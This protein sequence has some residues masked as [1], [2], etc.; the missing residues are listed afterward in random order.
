MTNGSKGRRSP[1]QVSRLDVIQDKVCAQLPSVIA[2][3]VDSIRPGGI[4]STKNS[5]ILA[6]VL[7]SRD[8]GEAI[9]ILLLRLRPGRRRYYFESTHASVEST[10]ASVEA[11]ELV[12]EQEQE[13]A[14]DREVEQDVDVASCGERLAEQEWRG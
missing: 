10:H 14:G 13:L 4:S 12:L 11:C 3:Q 8:L 5:T 1:G 2:H 9:T 7:H 6:S